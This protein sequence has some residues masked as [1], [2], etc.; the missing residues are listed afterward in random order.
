M[1]VKKLEE[2]KK[3]LKTLNTE[4]DKKLEETNYIVNLKKKELESLDINLINTSQQNDVVS[5]RNLAVFFHI[6]NFKLF[7]EIIFY[8]NQIPVP[9]DLYINIS[10]NDVSL[11]K[12]PEHEK[13]IKII[14]NSVKCANLYVTVSDNKGLD[15]GGFMI[16]YLKMLKLKI[17]YHSIIKLH[18]KSSD[19]WRFAMIYALLGNQKII[20][21]NLQ[22][23]KKN[24]IGMF[25]NYTLPILHQTSK[26]IMPEIEKLRILFNFDNIDGKFIPGTIFWIKGCVLDKYWNQEILN[27][28]YS[29]YQKNYCGLI[30]GKKEGAPHAYERFFGAMVKEYGL[31]TCTFNATNF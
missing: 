18:T 1:N 21:N 11:K 31:Q 13:K 16:S 9:Y 23:I 25:G 10:Y 20:S 22:L 2:K 3:I 19:S 17:R 12:T 26:I 30:I 7:D 4:K 8:I 5:Q 28:L 24:N 6:Y 14:K 29:S 27:N 15:I